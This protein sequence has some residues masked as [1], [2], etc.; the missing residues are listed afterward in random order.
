MK[1]EF[2]LFTQTT[3]QI[4][5]LLKHY[6]RER[7]LGCCLNMIA[8]VRFVKTS[9]IYVTSGEECHPGLTETTIVKNIDDLP[10]NVWNPW[11]LAIVSRTSTKLLH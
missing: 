5:C 1:L 6:L 10:S 4:G 7:P 11:D 9:V 8:T 3:I 2:S